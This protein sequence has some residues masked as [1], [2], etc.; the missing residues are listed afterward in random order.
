MVDVATPGL[1]RALE[2]HRV[3]LMSHCYRMLG[4]RFEAEDAVQETMVRA[5]RASDGFEGRAALRTWLY[6]IATNVC[7]D[8]QQSR[9]RRAL[10]MDLVSVC[11]DDA[12]VSRRLP[13]HCWLQPMTDGR[14]APTD[15]PA[16]FVARR[17]AIRD[18]FVAVIE[19]LPPRQ[20]AVLVLREVLRWKAIEVAEL[21][22]ASV[23]AV[24]SM[25]QRARAAFSEADLAAG[26]SLRLEDHGQQAQL[27]RYIDAFERVDVEGLVSLLHEEATKSTG[28]GRDNR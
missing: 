10:P 4:S 16:E 15:D 12:A 26:E 22:D 1:E 20:R 9:R 27:S 6:R 21:L 7:I 28:P 3:Q 17:E 8:V 2:Q 13:E 18:A 14:A 5:W 24:N 23:A 19:H 11:P 25:L